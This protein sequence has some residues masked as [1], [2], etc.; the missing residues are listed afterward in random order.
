VSEEIVTK[1]IGVGA[2]GMAT[3][4]FF[5]VKRTLRLQDVAQEARDKVTEQRHT[6]VQRLL[7]EQRASLETEIRATRSDVRL[8]VG[9]VAEHGKLISGAAATLE[10]LSGRVRDTEKEVRQIIREGCAH[11]AKCEGGE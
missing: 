9:D 1:L 4:M 8:V 7:H 3:L 11:R 10:A 2:G 5:L 6:D